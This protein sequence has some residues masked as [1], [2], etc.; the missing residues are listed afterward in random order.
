[1]T[2]RNHFGALRHCA[3]GALA[4]LAATA[5]AQETAP[6]PQLTLPPT[7]FAQTTETRPLAITLPPAVN[8]VGVPTYSLVAGDDAVPDWLEFDADARI[9]QGTPPLDAVHAQPYS[10]WQLRYV[11]ADDNGRCDAGALCPRDLTF[12]VWNAPQVVAIDE[13]RW[14]KDQSVDFALPRLHY[15]GSARIASM[16]EPL[17]LQPFVY[18]LRGIAGINNQ[19]QSLPAGL[20]YDDPMNRIHGTPTELTASASSSAT[21]FIY[22]ATDA[23]GF[24]S[25]QTFTVHIDASPTISFLTNL[26]AE[27]ILQQQPLSYDLPRANG[28]APITYA[29]Q[30]EVPNGVTFALTD[31][32][33]QL[34]GHPVLTV[35]LDMPN[36]SLP[37][38]MTYTATDANGASASQFFIMRFAPSGVVLPPLAALH[39]TETRPLTATLPAATNYYGAIRYTLEEETSLDTIPQWISFDATTRLFNI[40]PPLSALD[41]LDSRRTINLR[42]V[43]VDSRGQWDS[44]QYALFIW[45]APHA[46]HAIDELQLTVDR[47]VNFDLPQLQYGAYIAPPPLAPFVHTLRGA[48]NQTLPNGITFDAIARTLSGTLTA[49]LA[50]S[51]FI[52]ASTDKNG[53]RVESTFTL[54][55]QFAPLTFDVTSTALTFYV[56]QDDAVNLPRANGGHAPL[57][58]T[59]TGALPSGITYDAAAHNIAGAPSVV[60]SGKTVTIATSDAA[61]Q[62]ATL[63]LTIIVAP[64][65]L[66]LPAAAKLHFVEGA[67]FTAIL[68]QAERAIGAVSYALLVNDDDSDSKELP[69][70]LSFDSSTRTLSGVLTHVADGFDFYPFGLRYFAI[71][72]R[73]WCDSQAADGESLC[74]RAIQLQ[75]WNAPTLTSSDYVFG[76]NRPITQPLARATYGTHIEPSGLA[77]FVRTLTGALGQ[78]LPQGLMYDAAANE[79]RGTPTQLTAAAQFIQRI[80]DNNGI[81]ATITFSITIGQPPPKFADDASTAF[82]FN[83]QSPSAHTL[84]TAEGAAPIQYALS[85]NLP[86]GLTHDAAAHTIGGVATEVTPARELILTA[87]DAN[88]NDTPLTITLTVLGTLTAPS[89]PLLTFIEGQAIALTLPPAINIF[90][91]ASYRIRAGFADSPPDWLHLDATSRILSGTPPMDAVHALARAEYSLLYVADDA[92]G[93]CAQPACAS[94]LYFDVWNAPTLTVGARSYSRNQSVNLTLPRITFGGGVHTAAQLEPAAFAPYAYTFGG[95]TASDA[96]PNGLTYDSVARII[97]GAATQ[98]GAAT[99]VYTAVANNLTHNETFSLTILDASTLAF[100]ADAPTVFRFQTKKSFR[101]LPQA[102]GVEPITYSLTGVAPDG[103]L[104]NGLTFAVT[105]DN[106]PH[107]HGTPHLIDSG[108][109]SPGDPRY[110]PTADRTPTFVATDANGATA[111]LVLTVSVTRGLQL[112]LSTRYYF[113][114]ETQAH[115]ISLPAALRT[116][117]EVT[118][119]IEEQD[120]VDNIPDWLTFDASTRILH[121]HPPRDAVAPQDARQI[122]ALRYTAIDAGGSSDELGI[123]LH[124]WDAPQLAHAIDAQLYEVGDAVTLSLPPLHYGAARHIE[125]SALGAF[126]HQLLGVDGQQLPP[127]LT[128]DSN[129]LVLE[130]E[131][132]D[133]ASLS[134]FVYSA[135]DKNGF[136]AAQTF[137]LEVRY[138]LPVFN[139][140]S[141]E[142]TFYAQTAVDYTLPRVTGGAPSVQYAL[143]GALPNGLIHQTASHSIGGT[144]SGT[145]AASLTLTATD[146]IGESASMVLTFII[147]DALLTLPQPDSI[148]LTETLPISA[149]LPAASRIIGTATYAIASRFEDATPPNW[150]NFDGNTRVL[151]GAFDDVDDG[152]RF[153]QVTLHYFAGDARGQCNTQLTDCPRAFKVSVWNTPTL[154][155]AEM[156][157]EV[158][159]TVNTPLARLRYSNVDVAPSALA[160][161]RYE[162]VGL[163]GALLP[164]GLTFDA[165]A[166]AL[167]GAPTQTAQDAQFIH[168]ASDKN[169]YTAT[170]TFA[171][172]VRSPAA[173]EFPPDAPSEL[174]FA[175]H[176]AVNYSLPQAVGVTPL[177][178]TLHGELPQGMAFSAGGETSGEGGATLVGAPNGIDA[179]RT[180]TYTV[181]AGNAQ[182]AQLILTIRVF[183]APAFAPQAYAATYTQTAVTHT[184]GGAQFGGLTIAAGSG[185]V[186]ALDY[187]NAGQLPS[188]ITRIDLPGDALQLGGAPSQAGQFTFLRI[189]TDAVGAGTYTLFI[190]VHPAVTFGAQ[191]QSRL[192]ATIEG[193]ALTA[194]LPRAQDGFGALRYALSPTVP[195]LIFDANAVALTI[196]ANIGILQNSPGETE[197]TLRAVDD[198]G[199]SAQL[200]FPLQLHARLFLPRPNPGDVTFTVGHAQSVSFAQLTG[201]RAPV[202]AA[203][204]LT[205]TSPSTTAALSGLTYDDNARVLS[206]TF[207]AS[208]SAIELTF[209][210]TDANAAIFHHPFTLAAIAAPNFSANATTAFAAGYT[211]RAHRAIVDSTLPPADDGLPPLSYHWSIGANGASNDAAFTAIALHAES[212]ALS[213][214]PTALGDH[215]LSLHA[216]DQNGA[217]VSANVNLFI[218]DT[219][220][221]AQDN[222]QFSGGATVNRILSAAQNG[223]G[224][225][226]YTLT[227]VDGVGLDDLPSGLQ[228]DAATRAV[229]G[230][231]PTSASATFILTAADDFDA[232]TA[233]TTFVIDVF[234][235]PTFAPSPMLVTFTQGARTFSGGGAR[236]ESLTLPAASGGGALSYSVQHNLPNGLTTTMIA[237]D[238][239]L[240]S[241]ATQSVGAFS[242]VRLA[243]DTLDASRVGTFT[244][245]VH[246]ANPPTFA[247]SNNVHL[248]T[249]INGVAQTVQLPRVQNGVGAALYSIAPS[250]QTNFALDVNTAQL[251]LNP[252]NGDNTGGVFN[253]TLTAI[254]QNGASASKAFV[255][256]VHPRLTFAGVSPSDVTYTVGIDKAITFT[257]ANGGRAP[258]TYA[259]DLANIVVA[260]RLTFDVDSRTLRGGF[261]APIANAPLTYQA[262][263]ANG[264]SLQHILRTVAAPAPTFP[265]NTP[266]AV[267]LAHNQSANHPLP[268]AVGGAMPIAYTLIGALP[269]GLRFDVDA[270]Q[271]RG[272]PSAL[273]AAQTVTLRATDDNG[274]IADLAMSITIA[275]APYFE[276]APADITFTVGINKSVNLPQAGGAGA[277]THAL[278]GAPVWLDVSPA[279]PSTNPFVIS[280]TARDGDADATL[281]FIATDSQ[282]QSVTTLFDVVVA[283]ALRFPTAQADLTFSAGMPSGAR[284]LARAAGGALPL[285]YELRSR[286]G[287][288]LDGLTLSAAAAELRG[289]PRGDVGAIFAV[290]L[291]V[292][293]VNGAVAETDF[294]LHIVDAP[295]FAESVG[296][297]TMTFGAYTVGQSAITAL[298]LPRAD[299]GGGAISYRLRTRGATLIDGDTIGGLT[300]A[301]GARHLLFGVPR[302]AGEY[303]LT[304][305]AIDANGAMSAPV[306][307]VFAVV[308]SLRFVGANL[309]S[310]SVDEAYRGR[311]QRFALPKIQG[312]AMPF[313]YRLDLSPEE[314]GATWFGFDDGDAA[315]NNPEL[316][317]T[318]T[319]QLFAALSLAAEQN[320][321]LPSYSYAY[322]VADANDAVVATTVVID[323]TFLPRDDFNDINQ[324]ILSEVSAAIVADTIG[325]IGERIAQFQSDIQGAPTSSASLTNP[326]AFAHWLNAHAPALANRELRAKELLRGARLNLSSGNGIDR[327]RGV[328][329]WMSGEYREMSADNDELKWN[330]DLRGAMLGIDGALGKRALLGVAIG[331]A[332]SDI[333]YEDIG[334]QQLAGKGEY[335]L[336]VNTVNPYIT[337]NGA[338]ANWWVSLGYGEGDLEITR[339]AQ[340]VNGGGVNGDEDEIIETDVTLHTAALGVSALVRARQNFELRLRAEAIATR[341]DI[342]AAE[343]DSAQQLAAQQLDGGLARLGIESRK[344]IALNSGGQFAPHYAFGARHDF[345]DGDLGGGIEGGG[346][347]HFIGAQQ[348]ISAQLR[349][350]GAAAANGEYDEWGAYAQLRKRAGADGQRWSANITPQYQKT[351]GGV[352]VASDGLQL[353]NLESNLTAERFKALTDADDAIDNDYALQLTARLAYGITAAQGLWTPFMQWTHA[354]DDGYRFGLDWTPTLSAA[355]FTLNLSANRDDDSR[356][357]LLRG[358]MGF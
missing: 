62:N 187:R 271:L 222:V 279:L 298:T 186:G 185:A 172:G 282:G 4:L 13:Q 278:T 166:N 96:L 310:V 272:T 309:I 176:A 250:L 247:T 297:T 226:A 9:V 72:E 44:A 104:P 77:P 233:Q 156:Q 25:A 32:G 122:H 283:R 263:D 134:S 234:D 130:G 274:A 141:L 300:Y 6:P 265:A 181:T 38:V 34:T 173:P 323:L 55:A 180:V 277:L 60:D 29:L 123:T 205:A 358:V 159:A 100:A 255:V 114:T 344:S 307:I 203:V 18:A 3:F 321:S 8:I 354:A 117:G 285:R 216:T 52:Y 30:G 157:L 115:S 356:G 292:T 341:L 257:A 351:N 266:P 41:T 68:P 87:T 197:M 57:M 221:I 45:S 168:S 270:H 58:H 264:A 40:A 26:P 31:D 214:T 161:Y 269:N 258:L 209:T 46:T 238:E 224:A 346:G 304:F 128:Y 120:A 218:A 210:V 155:A 311:A 162:L 85:G 75:V 200:T 217:S 315:L 280:A 273:I 326:A 148:H 164:P 7:P 79:L 318:F 5:Q 91:A 126:T 76:V 227:D 316:I 348:R 39:L 98:P 329:V 333:E 228:F 334:E 325:A 301:V 262:T 231:A 89:I 290:T 118:Y 182:T 119:A 198:N 320:E 143:N 339:E 230:V 27:I 144:P 142:L 296:G 261:D 201:G 193:V 163:G 93:A 170:A 111:S 147:G 22:T 82:T 132:T 48:D 73:G 175:N 276:T 150:I 305:T 191:T 192:H 65:K 23:N 83:I 33:A 178:Y 149:T 208:T 158:G 196:S 332:Q 327:R 167:R 17:E 136:T 103:E 64:R 35:D 235:K 236:Y 108:V 133:S 183:N 21:S 145:G 80:T 232:Q 171:L 61:E 237:D 293:D 199:A 47:A 15:G 353:T 343:L 352:N 137:A 37:H 306:L 249:T 165:D 135:R 330:G 254:D 102:F 53:Y 11:V 110:D 71:D 189:A 63:T 328:A 240:L 322:N 14:V 241:G 281:T 20:T 56:D 49:P 295:M 314:D 174:T 152:V 211:F 42:Y 92:R 154:D 294:T 275:G 74:P 287:A 288:S 188:G 244:L 286:D 324:Q 256:Q 317:V 336:N 220:T 260:N 86:N 215:A 125:P 99:F 138:P 340:S 225:V 331:N 207:A 206:G 253:Y 357:V 106:R 113:L 59:L 2:T 349:I 116:I 338:R 153:A 112:Q 284:Q 239:L 101:F 212:R 177:L 219:L 51:D 245:T 195:N 243:I 268:R 12:V 184:N 97:H 202:T 313:V 28:V 302:I 36:I 109:T 355:E 88:S 347:I 342:D 303:A 252:R 43:A 131:P 319:P 127:G 229:S 223:V 69:Q 78:S 129:A 121:A 107:L 337:R 190:E 90:G 19:S 10:Q 140:A 139:N 267:T 335:K 345:G 291:I 194:Q 350:H 16:R 289:A 213:G 70:W 81:D 124:L 1:M 54:S 146:A 84:P 95:Q 308:D 151:S 67:T 169:G 94:D 179:G 24:I 299:G 312:G 248:H 251:T 105:T 246:V 259:L 204:A 242:F 66:R 50:A 160:P